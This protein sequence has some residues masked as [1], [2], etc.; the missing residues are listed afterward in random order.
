MNL[1]V[2]AVALFAG[3]LCHS[4]SQG[5]ASIV[6]QD[7]LKASNTSLGLRFN[8]FGFTVS[9]ANDASAIV[10][11]SADLNNPK[12]SP[13]QTIVFNNGLVNFTDPEWT[14]YP[15]RFYRVRSQ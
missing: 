8:E 10:E 1:L 14:K 15:S 7:Y 3:G 12:G 11:A 9:W 13:L 5:A 6:Q 2:P 4:R